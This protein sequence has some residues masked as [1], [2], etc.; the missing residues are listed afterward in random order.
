MGGWPIPL[1]KIILRGYPSPCPSPLWRDR[2]GDVP[3]ISGNDS[4]ESLPLP[5]SAKSLPSVPQRPRSGGASLWR[6]RGRPPHTGRGAGQAALIA[7]C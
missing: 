1:T 3:S 4:T 7:G 2:G 6:G 5:E